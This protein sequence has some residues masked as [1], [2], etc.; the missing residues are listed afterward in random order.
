MLC[1]RC[2]HRAKYLEDLAKLKQK[3]TVSEEYKDTFV[4]S[5][6]FECS[7]IESSVMGCY[8]YKPVKPIAIKPREGDIR[9]LSLNMFSC[10][11]GRVDDVKVELELQGE[12][13]ND[14]VI[15]YWVPKKNEE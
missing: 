3:Y 13:I 15:F 14:S 8:M 6:R 2:Q 12:Q 7:Q 4:S 5:P 10:R 1:Y 11:V 9:P